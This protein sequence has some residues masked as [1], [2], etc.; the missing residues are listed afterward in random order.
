MI[1]KECGAVTVA[2]GGP[3]ST[4]GWPGSAGW[5]N[6]IAAEGDLR[7]TAACHPKGGLRGAGAKARR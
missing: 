7:V 5:G 4:P 3:L 1:G 6:D 2:G